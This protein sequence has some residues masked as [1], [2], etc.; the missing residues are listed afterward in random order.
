MNFWRIISG[1]GLKHVDEQISKQKVI[2]L[3]QFTLVSFLVSF[4]GVLNLVLV[5]EDY[6]SALFLVV[7]DIIISLAF[8]LTSRGYFKISKW[9]LLLTVISTIF[10]L[11][12]YFGFKSGTFLYYF[13]LTLVIAYLFDA[14]TELKLIVLLTLATILSAIIN[15]ITNYT[16]FETHLLND[17]QRQIIF[18]FNLPI[19]LFSLFYFVYLSI[20]NNKLQNRLLE[21]RLSEKQ[22]SEAVINKSLKEK[23]LLLAELHHRVKNNLALI[24]SLLN[25]GLQKNLDSETV[26]LESKNRVQSISFIHNLLYRNQDFSKISFSTY[27]DALVNEINASYPPKNGKAIH[28]EK[29]IFNLDLDIK[30]AIPCGLLINELLTNSYK[31][32]FTNEIDSPTISIN[33][34]RENLSYY[35]E[36]KDNGVGFSNK[37]SNKKSSGMEIIESLCDQLEANYNFTSDGGVIFKAWF[38]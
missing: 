8:W 4:L 37:N 10:F 12:S 11:D 27:I 33:F 13:P 17:S 22:K 34:K 14:K 20:Q 31:H 35:L 24:S 18:Y 16:F 28:V 15:L 29:N 5:V 19:C 32:A 1:N 7:V 26:L 23:E 3:N 21:E 9:L 2:L 30:T 38:N 6:F 36:V 25:F